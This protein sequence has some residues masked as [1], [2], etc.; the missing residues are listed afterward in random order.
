[1]I[2]QDKCS[3]WQVRFVEELK[4]NDQKIWEMDYPYKRFAVASAL[5]L[6]KITEAFG[7]SET[8][9]E[10]YFISMPDAKGAPAEYGNLLGDIPWQIISLNGEKLFWIPGK[11]IL[12]NSGTMSTKFFQ[13][14]V[15]FSFYEAELR[16]LEKEIKESWS[17][18]EKDIEF[19]YQVT[20]SSIQQS[21][22]VNERTRQ[23]TLQRMRC[24]RIKEL[25]DRVSSSAGLLEQLFERLDCERRLDSVEA[26]LEIYEDVY[27]LANDRISEFKYFHVEAKLEIFIIFLLL[28]EVVVMILELWM[29][30][31]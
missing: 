15:A 12:R 10:F 21:S 14:L 24:I 28:A 26:Q 19:T 18:V 5:A 7:S 9:G 25:L 11:A 27:E 20:P 31:K 22:H 13:Y 29:L 8:S 6:E 4:N 23:V 16:K 2:S 3:L 1:M 30:G 17:S